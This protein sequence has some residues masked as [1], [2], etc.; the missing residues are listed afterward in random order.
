MHG[1]VV[2]VLHV[3]VD[4]VVRNQRHIILVTDDIKFSSKDSSNSRR[5]HQKR[6]AGLQRNQR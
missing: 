5:P 2:D 3:H 4:N 1:Q 6:R